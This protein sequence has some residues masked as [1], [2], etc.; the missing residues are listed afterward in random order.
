MKPLRVLSAAQAG[1]VRALRFFVV[2][3]SFGPANLFNYRWPRQLQAQRV[4]TRR[5]SL[6]KSLSANDLHSR[7]GSA[8]ILPYVFEFFHIDSINNQFLGFL[9]FDSVCKRFM[10]TLEPSPHVHSCAH[11]DDVSATNRAVIA[12][13]EA[14]GHAGRE[15]E[16]S[17]LSSARFARQTGS[18]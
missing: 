5:L 9:M 1:A 15:Q 12:V 10:L 2:C 16:N 3:W 7:R 14:V 13:V 6:R 17:S 18:A 11:G 4:S 8:F